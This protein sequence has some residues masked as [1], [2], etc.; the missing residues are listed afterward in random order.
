MSLF[1]RLILKAG[2]QAPKELIYT[3]DRG[4]LKTNHGLVQL[5]AILP[6]QTSA[7]LMIDEL[8]E[9]PSANL[10]G[11]RPIE[12]FSSFDLLTTWLVGSFVWKPIA[13]GEKPHEKTDIDVAFIDADEPMRFINNAY[14]ILM[15][16]DRGGDSLSISVNKFGSPRLINMS[17]RVLIDAFSLPAGVSIAEHVSV[18]PWPH[19]RCAFL[20]GAE[21]HDQ[22]RILR[23]VR[24]PARVNFMSGD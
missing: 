7:S 2:A 18:Y 9:S 23:I 21:S 19:Q 24:P 6:N 8:L 22:N 1:D 5:P 17:G 12:L 14:R 16:M 15:A 10:F 20:I 4:H 3:N 13:L 11:L